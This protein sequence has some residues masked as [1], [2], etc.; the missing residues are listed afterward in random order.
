[1]K[2]GSWGWAHEGAEGM[3]GLLWSSGEDACWAG[4]HRVEEEGRGWRVFMGID[5]TSGCR[6]R[7]GGGIT[8]ANLTAW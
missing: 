3:G 2:E 7:V 8:E 4:L 5:E 6:S 1:M